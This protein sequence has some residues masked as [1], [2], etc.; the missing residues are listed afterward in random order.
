MS[1]LRRIVDWFKD[2]RPEPET[3]DEPP[4]EASKEPL[5]PAGT[6]EPRPIQTPFIVPAA[7][8]V[9]DF[10]V[11]LH[12]S[13]RNAPGKQL[14]YV[15]LEQLAGIYHDTAVNSFLKTIWRLARTLE[16]L[17]PASA[18]NVMNADR[19]MRQGMCFGDDNGM[20]QCVPTVRVF[21]DP[22][23]REEKAPLELRRIKIEEEHLSQTLRDHFLRE[24]TE[25]WLRGLQQLEQFAEL[26][27][28]ERQ[29][30]LLFAASMVDERFSKV[31]QALAR[32]RERRYNDLV[33][34]LRRAV[35]DH[36][37]LGLF[38]FAN[39][40][41]K[42]LQAFCR[43]MGVDIGQWNLAD[44]GE[45]GPADSETLEAQL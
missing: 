35:G 26:G 18:E 30:L 4:E 12:L 36:E 22:K 11:I 41:D 5:R 23:L 21:L 42:A 17:H 45:A 32:D 38:E 34:V 40:Y 44:F 3:I 39:A 43:Q 16:P 2:P 29:F 15:R 1:F 10:H 27:K 7:G 14:E 13:W 6:F 28:D 19:E 33:G 25:S 24:R 9:F 20:V 8:D 37:R 31:T